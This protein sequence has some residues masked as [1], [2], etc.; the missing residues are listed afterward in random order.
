MNTKACRKSR[1]ISPAHGGLYR[2]RYTA[3]RNI[4]WIGE[5]ESIAMCL[6]DH[7]WEGFYKGD[8]VSGSGRAT[9]VFKRVRGEWKL[10]HEHLSSLSKG[11]TNE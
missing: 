4:N 1:N 6:Y 3:Y 7:H 2:R 11:G 5:S 9:N 8:K 10:I